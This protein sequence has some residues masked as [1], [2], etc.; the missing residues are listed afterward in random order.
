MNSTVTYLM[1]VLEDELSKKQIAKFTIT[2]LTRVSKLSRSTIYYYFED[3]DSVYRVFV[4]RFI[5]KKIISQNSTFEDFVKEVLDYISENRTLSMNLYRLTLKSNSRRYFLIDLTN[6]SFSQYKAHDF[7]KREENYMLAGFL[8]I[9]LFWFES[10]LQSD[11]SQILQQILDYGA[12]F[13]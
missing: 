2:D 1:H 4:Q 8:Y 11:Q 7:Q 9:F 13:E 5:V 3:L 10:G 12:L 6:Q